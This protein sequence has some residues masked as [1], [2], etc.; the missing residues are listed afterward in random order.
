MQLFNSIISGTNMIKTK[1]KEIPLS[2]L[3]GM[4]KLGLFKGYVN[5]C[6]IQGMK[7]NFLFW[8]SV[9]EVNNLPF[10]DSVGNMLNILE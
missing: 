5:H 9:V 4:S 10:C 7:C 6:L 1:S 2:I 8:V 3:R